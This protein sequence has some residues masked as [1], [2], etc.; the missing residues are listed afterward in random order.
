MLSDLSLKGPKRSFVV[1]SVNGGKGNVA[2]FCRSTRAEWFDENATGA[3]G[4]SAPSKL[5]VK[6]IPGMEA[7]L[8]DLNY[9]LRYFDG[10]AAKPDVIPSCG[11]V[12]QGSRGTGKSM[13]LE[14]IATTRWGKVVDITR[15]DKPSTILDYFTN[16]ID[17]RRPTLILIDD[18]DELVGKGRP[19]R[20]GH[21]DAFKNGLGDLAALMAK[22]KTRPSVVVVATCRNYLEDIPESLQADEIFDNHITL[23]IPDSS[24]RKEI[25]RYRNPYFP[26][27]YSEQYI[28]DLGDRTHAYTGRDLK[29]LIVRA[30]GISD[31]RTGAYSEENPLIWSDVQ[32]A[33][34][35]VP[36][37]AMH[38]ITLKPPTIRWND[39]GG[40]QDVKSTLQR[41]LAPPAAGKRRWKPPKGVLLYGP[42]GC[43]K[44]MTAQAMATESGFNFFAVKGG[45]LLNMYVGETERSIRNLFKRAREASPS[46]IFFDE[47]ESLASSR[48]PGSSVG[49]VQAV[50]TLL[51][52][53]DGFE[54]MGDI[55]VLAATNKP[56]SLDP[57]ILRPGRFDELI[58]VPL[59]DEQ[60]RRAIL[61]RKS[62]ELWLPD[63]VVDID[64]LAKKTSGYS[65]AEISRICDRAFMNAGDSETTGEV[66]EGMSVLETAIQNTPKRVTKDMLDHYTRWHESRVK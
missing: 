46:I 66:T 10:R 36:P 6:D 19:N 21:I 29:K 14:R 15:T 40:Y 47:I 60:A 44:T 22:E 62:T 52:E 3:D 63:L 16:A 45:E 9:F 42:P 49:G 48:A 11:I 13:I 28:S 35:E 25:I 26:A 31:R 55:F 61:L 50:T 64:E 39:I 17:S 4:A 33:L 43:S 32:K 1:E 54:Q 37:T 34:Q 58:Y 51:T 5:E 53:M 57:A 12:I 18:I 65:G 23:P 38:D 7:P 20:D 8:S 59:P 24:A 41:V 2:R 56:E 30:C 27:E